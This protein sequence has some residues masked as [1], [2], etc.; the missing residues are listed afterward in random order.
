MARSEGQN[1]KMVKGWK[2]WKT[3]YPV[4]K[5]LGRTEGLSVTPG[6]DERLANLIYSFRRKKKVVERFLFYVDLTVRTWKR[7]EPTY[8]NQGSRLG[9]HCREDRGVTVSTKRIL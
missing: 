8:R 2:G 5:S 6:S 1:K 7:G 4:K 9:V 3:I